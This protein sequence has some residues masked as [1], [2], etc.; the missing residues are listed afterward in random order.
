MAWA[1]AGRESRVLMDADVFHAWIGTR[2]SMLDN[3]VRSHVRGKTR[4]SDQALP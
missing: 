1:M 3:I 4:L 2:K